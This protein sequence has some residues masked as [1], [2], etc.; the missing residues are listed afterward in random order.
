MKA[1][2]PEIHSTVSAEFLLLALTEQWPLLMVGLSSFFSLMC[3]NLM[4]I[5]MNRNG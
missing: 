2:A 1:G 4:F 3:R 5:L